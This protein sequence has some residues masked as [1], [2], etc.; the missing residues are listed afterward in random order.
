[1]QISLDGE[2]AFQFGDAAAAAASRAHLEA[3]SSPSRRET[4]MKLSPPTSGDQRLIQHKSGGNH[5]DARHVLLNGVPIVSLVIDGQ[6]RLCLAQISNTLL[7]QFSYNEIHNRRVALGIT[8]VQCTP[9]QLEIL[10]RAGAMPISSRRCGMITKREAER[11]CKSFL[12]ENEPPKLPEDF[13]FDIY[14]ECA[15]GSRGSFIPV[16]YNS[17]RAK[18]I[19][20]SFCNLFFSPNKFI[21]HSHR[22]PCSKYVQPDA[23]NFNSWRRH[24]RLSDTSNDD[25]NFAWEDVKAMFNGGSRKRAMSPSVSNVSHNMQA[26]MNKRSRCSSSAVIGA[27]SGS[28][29]QRHHHQ[30]DNPS[31]VATTPLTATPVTLT[32]R[33]DKTG[34][35]LPM[36]P[37]PTRTYGTPC[38]QPA[39]SGIPSDFLWNKSSLAA[40]ATYPHN[41]SSLIWGAANHGSILSPSLL[42]KPNLAN[43]WSTTYCAAENLPFVDLRSTINMYS[44]N[45][46]CHPEVGKSAFKPVH[47]SACGDCDGDGVPNDT[48]ENKAEESSDSDIEVNETSDDDR[49]NNNNNNNGIVAN[50]T[51]GRQS[52]PRRNSTPGDEIEIGV[53]DVA[54]KPETSDDVVQVLPDYDIE[55][56]TN[57]NVDVED[58]R[59]QFR[60]SSSRETESLDQLCIKH[61]KNED[62]GLQMKVVRESFL[63][64]LEEERATRLAVQQK[65]REAHEALHKVSCDSTCNCK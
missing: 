29:R 43:P 60:R 44:G 58:Q 49:N 3:S 18:C 45:R 48:E 1:S 26:A 47:R 62:I 31:N 7:K 33:I 13:A 20:C 52:D 15:W 28:S 63:Q 34:P 10:R 36:I 17:S 30:S 59:N 22:L 2:V 5:N 27:P 50:S 51:D 24:I 53:E 19:R 38:F 61:H 37:F 14:H 39:T 32:Q 6:E 41:L 40:N 46:H 65:L 12:C 64:K 42:Q 16:R 9:V 56:K 54:K 21:F 23:A 8:C 11:L 4:K 57:E 35:Y 55:I 25:V